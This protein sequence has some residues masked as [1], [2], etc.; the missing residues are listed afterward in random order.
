MQ[1]PRTHTV[2]APPQGCLRGRGLGCGAARRSD[3]QLHRQLDPVAVVTAAGL[4]VFRFQ[5]SGTGP[6]VRPSGRP[7]RLRGCPGSRQHHPRYGYVTALM[8]TRGSCPATA[9]NVGV[10]L[11]T[12]PAKQRELA[13]IRGAGFRGLTAAVAAC[14][15]NLAAQPRCRAEHLFR[16]LRLNGQVR[17]PIRGLPVFYPLQAAAEACRSTP[18]MR[19]ASAQLEGGAFA[20]LR[21]A[22]LPANSGGTITSPEEGTWTCGQNLLSQR[23]RCAAWRQPVATPPASASSTVPARAQRALR[24]STPTWSPA[25]LSALP[26][27]SFTAN[28]TPANAE[29]AAAALNSRPSGAGHPV[30]LTPCLGLPRARRFAFRNTKKQGTAYV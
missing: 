9:R 30:A 28:R 11:H 25:P 22:L 14:I 13:Q 6:Q 5:R 18:P 10:N 4:P 16:P 21:N 26:Q 2:P 23:S 19:Q 12:G 15:V 29:A 17:D 1:A 7:V 8:R 24:C 20:P 3:V 27:T